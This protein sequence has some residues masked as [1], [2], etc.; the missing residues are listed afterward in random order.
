MKNFVRVLRLVLNHRPTLLA[1]VF[2]ALAVAALWVV[3]IGGI[4]PIVEVIFH[5]QSLQEWVNQQIKDTDKNTA[6]F[7]EKI[8]GLQAELATAVDA[9]KLRLESQIAAVEHRR[10]NEQAAADRYRWWKPYIDDYL[11]NDP[12]QTLF[13]IMMVLLAGTILKDIALVFD[14]VLVDRLTNLCVLDLRKKFF[15]RTLRMDLASFGEAGTS[16][17]MSRF[18]N[19]TDAVGGGV[20]VVLGKV[21]REPLKMLGC[22]IGAAWICWR[23]L[24]FSLL[25][26]PV[27]GYLVG[28]LAKSLKRANRRAL[29]Q[30]S[31]FYGILAETFGGIK[32]V[33]AFTME[34]YERRRFHLNIKEAFKKSMKISWYDSMVNPLTEMMGISA[35]CSAV[36][37]G[38]YLVLRHETDLL[39]IKMSDRPLSMGALLVFYGFL[40]GAIDPA[41]KLSEVFGRLQRASAAADRIF[42]TMDR[43]TRVVDP[44]HAALLPRHHQDIVLK[45]V[46]FHYTPDQ[47]VLD[48]INLRIEFGE[49]IAIVGP[50]GCGKTTLASLIPRFFDPVQGTVQL[51]GVNLRDV[52]LTDLRRQIGIVTQETLLFDDTVLANIRYGTPHATREQIIAAAQQAHAHRFIEQKLERGYET[53]VGPQGNRLSGGQRQRIALA[54]AILRDPAILILDEATSQIDLESEQLIQM[55]LEQFVRNRTAIIITHRLSTL[56]LADRIVV[57]QAGRI[58]DVGRHDELMGRCDFYQRLYQ[59]QFKESA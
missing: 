26:A 47:K 49:T 15:R 31:T 20:Q 30:T 10:D 28:R 50:N 5:D 12:F 43:E 4:Y 13:V 54:R 25:L 7:E 24:F 40:V 21:V 44:P 34:R 18:T 17:L 56:D 58:L 41:R 48:G 32:V 27:M 53:V 19:D 23:L 46:S 9:E 14:S 22:F 29:E 2:S 38:A 33:K 42:Q 8:A 6:A 55:T 57:M 39:G 59:I 1:S 52:K 37:A 35:I 45:D 16:E 51:D 11:P 3:N 36:L